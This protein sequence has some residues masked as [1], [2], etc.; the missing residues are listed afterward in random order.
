MSAATLIMIYGIS[1][2]QS[3]EGYPSKKAIL[4]YARKPFAIM[5]GTITCTRGAA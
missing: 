1:S 3:Y 2:A 5:Y 4:A